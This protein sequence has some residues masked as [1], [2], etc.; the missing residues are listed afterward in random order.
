MLFYYT[1]NFGLRVKLNFGLNNFK[2]IVLENFHDH[3][4]YDHH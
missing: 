4:T 1:A 2:D 3:L